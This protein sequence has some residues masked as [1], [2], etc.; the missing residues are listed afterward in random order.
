M[1]SLYD[2]VARSTWLS[3]RRGQRA[4]DH[5]E[6]FRRILHRRSERPLFA[7]DLAVPRDFD[8]GIGDLPG[9]YLYSL[10]DLQHACEANRRDREKNGLRPPASLRTRRL[11]SWRN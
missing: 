10:D 7:L 1:G 5:P 3:A 11:G 8:P 6:Q 2:Q 9:V 4:S